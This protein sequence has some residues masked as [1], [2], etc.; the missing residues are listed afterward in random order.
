MKLT[1]RL[2]STNVIAVT[3]LKNSVT[4][5]VDTGA[6]VTA[7]IID[8]NDQP[9]AGE[10]WPKALPHATAGTYR[11]SISHELEVC[12]RATYLALVRAVGSGGE[13]RQWRCPVDLTAC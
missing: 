1:L 4:G 10:T 9:V 12:P 5:V 8:A 6:T 7:T 13:V 2:G 11:A 3:G